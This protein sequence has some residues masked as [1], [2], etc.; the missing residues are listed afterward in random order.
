MPLLPAPRTTGIARKSSQGF[1]SEHTKNSSLYSPVGNSTALPGLLIPKAQKIQSS[2]QTNQIKK[3]N[4]KNKY[5][6]Q[7]S[8][9]F[10]ETLLSK[11]ILKFEEGL[12]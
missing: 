11:E 7:N 4:I 10:A 12:Q 1:I 6:N 5:S 2:K 8:D 3:A 9:P